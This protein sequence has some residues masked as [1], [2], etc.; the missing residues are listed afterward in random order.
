MY[1]S[2]MNE[3]NHQVGMI[4]MVCTRSIL[5]V[6]YCCFRKR[7]RLEVV[8]TTNTTALEAAAVQLTPTLTEYPETVKQ[9]R[10]KGSPSMFFVSVETRQCIRCLKP[11]I[12]DTIHSSSPNLCE[13]QQRSDWYWRLPHNT[14]PQQGACGAS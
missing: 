1:L 5:G 2:A 12:Q 8:L 4:C 7:G 13:E 6:N 10:D 9:V 14:Q 3:L 11:G